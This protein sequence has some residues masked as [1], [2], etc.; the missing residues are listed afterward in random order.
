MRSGSDGDTEGSCEPVE[1][2]ESMDRRARIL[3]PN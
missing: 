2:S 3:T 1:D